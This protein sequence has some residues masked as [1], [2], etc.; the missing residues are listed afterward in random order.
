M[1]ILNLT[2]DSFSD[3]SSY[4]TPSHALSAARD[5]LAN[6]ANILDLGGLSTK[7]GSDP[8]SVKD[9]I[10]RVV[11]VIKLLREE[12]RLTCP[13]SIDTYRPEVAR[14]ALEAGANCINDV[15]GG[16]EPGMLEV[17]AEADVPVILMHSRGTSATMSSLTSYPRHDVVQGVISE[18]SETVR[19]A[20]AA[21]VKRYNIVLDPG[22]GFAKTATQNL[23]LLANLDRIVGL[24]SG[25]PL[26]GFPMLVGA[27]RKRFIGEL[28][29]QA[30]PRERGYGSAAV[31]AGCVESGVVQVV[32]VHDTRETRD[33]VVVLEAIKKHKRSS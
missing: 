8:V 9:E 28:T 4:P 26:E 12:G 29:C 17:M 13:I 27:S 31:V 24:A 5:M 18:L 22:I 10:A 6:G 20:L 19:L 23:E 33:L 30:V 25:S 14:A 21:G 16:R 1:S 2:P 7:P 11:P 3:G 32:R 15:Y